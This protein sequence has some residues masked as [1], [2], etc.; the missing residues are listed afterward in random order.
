MWFAG[1]RPDLRRHTQR[2]YRRRARSERADRRRRPANSTEL[3]RYYAGDRDPGHPCYAWRSLLVSCIE[4]AR[5][6]SA[7][8][9][10]FRPP[11]DARLV[12]PGHDGVPGWWRRVGRLARCEPAQTDPVHREAAAGPGRLARLE[13][14]VH[15]SRS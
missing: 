9:R 6:L 7:E 3:A 11:R 14:A 8:F 5:A 15:L 10:L 1:R 12:N 2:L 13:M 4:R